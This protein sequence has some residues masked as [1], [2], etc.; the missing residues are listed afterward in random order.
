MVE[1]IRRAVETT[2]RPLS[3]LVIRLGMS[4]GTTSREAEA[5]LKEALDGL[6]R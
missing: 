2:G 4:A 3:T 6:P 1:V 5:V